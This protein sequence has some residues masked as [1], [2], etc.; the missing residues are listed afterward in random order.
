MRLISA[1]QAL[2][3][4][5]AAFLIC[6]QANAADVQTLAPNVSV[7]I[8]ASGNVIIAHGPEGALLVD[9]ERARDVAEIQAAVQQ[10]NAGPIRTVINTHW[11]LDHCGGNEA[12]AQAG[13]VIV[14]Q[15]N[16]RVRRSTEQFMPAYN[17]HIPAGSPAALPTI[18]FDETLEMHVGDETV[19]LR[20]AANAHTD[21]DT[22]VW[23]PHA[24]V[25]HMGDVYFH[26]IF[27]FIDRAS[28]GSIQ[29]VIASVDMALALAN[30]DTKIVPAHGD[31]AT[32]A[33]L[34]AYRA[35]LVDI[36]DRVRRA[37][38]GHRT[39]AQVIATH[40]TAAYHLDGDA[41]RLVSA[42]Y[43]SYSAHAGTH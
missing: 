23:F 31:I 6:A 5:A 35:M 40:P 18:V 34:M 19:M 26:G 36:R 1:L 28:G 32:K 37:M 10:L 24:N 25:I 12:L 2:G 42:I 22:I 16:V 41:D 15:K 14:A 17:S 11:H 39:E 38:R 43:D 3:G 30:D 20:H 8:G 33:D 9:D 13:A 27:P 7:L 21:G 4:A 29:G